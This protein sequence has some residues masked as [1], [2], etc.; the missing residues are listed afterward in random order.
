MDA[1]QQVSAATSAQPSVRTPETGAAAISSDFETFLRML[2]VQMQNQDPLNPIESSDFAVQ[3]ATF[4]GV[5]QQ[6][7]TNEL[8]ANLSSAL[9]GSSVAT[10]ADWIGKE[11][12]APAAA[13]FDGSP[14]TVETTV[15][16]GASA[17][18]LLVRDEFGRIVDRQPI[19]TTGGPVEW[20]GVSQLG[21]AFLAGNYTFV[22]ESR[23]TEGEVF[24]S[25]DGEVYGQITEA[26]VGASGDVELVLENGGVVR[27]DAVSA[28]RQPQGS[29]S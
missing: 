26:R 2:T 28:L 14:I 8:L 7:K 19:P 3:L 20:R 29:G 22:V 24:G 16:A 5:E 6:V 1:A 21:N 13:Y 15:S 4:S 25:V 10:Y 23:S 17:A 9:N 12:R 27:P 18:D 11:A